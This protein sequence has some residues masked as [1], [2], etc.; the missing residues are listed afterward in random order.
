MKMKIAILQSNYIPWKGYFDLINMVDT[1]VLFDTVQFTRR[2]WRNRNKIKTQ[3][4]LE[5]LTIPVQVKGNYSQ[6]IQ[7]TI[8]A[9]K[10][11]GKKHWRTIQHHYAKTKYFSEYKDI[12]EHVYLDFE[13]KYLSDINYRFLTQINTILSIETKICWSRDFKLGADKNEN[14]LEICKDC[15]ATDYISG[16]AAKSYL[17]MALFQQ[18]D[19]N[20]TWMDYSNYPQYTQLHP[21]FDHG[22]TILDL[23]FNEGSK[24]INF[25]K[26][27]S[28]LKDNS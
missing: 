17:D 15:H 13:D 25:M 21:P 22:V 9:Q 28:A 19:I 3:N 12:F 5:W 7:D 23:I 4:G 18:E 11:W 26:S 14:L 8:V 20:V 2:D 24:S 1:F 6:T 16:P 27:F 10:D